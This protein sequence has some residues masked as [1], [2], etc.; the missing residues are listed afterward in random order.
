MAMT[1]CTRAA[2]A[3]TKATASSLR[4]GLAGAGFNQGALVLDNADEGPH[5]LGVGELIQPS[6]SSISRSTPLVAMGSLSN[7]HAITVRQNRINFNLLS[8][9]F[10]LYIFYSFLVFVTT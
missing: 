4:S 1:P 2:A 5:A 10:L 3:F 7:Q 6:S 8:C 9:I